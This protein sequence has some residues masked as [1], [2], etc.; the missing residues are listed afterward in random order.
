[1][2]TLISFSRT[3]L[4]VKW[5]APLGLT[6]T[7]L[8]LTAGNTFAQSNANGDAATETAAPSIAIKH[9]AS[10]SYLMPGE[11]A[12][13]TVVVT[14]T[15]NVTLDNVK[16]TNPNVADCAHQ[17]GEMTP[18]QVVAYSCE[19]AEIY[20]TTTS[21]VTV[22]GSATNLP[23]VVASAEAQIDV[24]NAVFSIMQ[25]PVQGQARRGD[26]IIMTYNY[27]NSGAGAAIGVQLVEFVPDGTNFVPEA[28][29]GWTCENGSIEAGTM[30][31]Y[32]IER[33]EAGE[34]ASGQ[35]PFVVVKLAD[36]ADR[37]ETT[38]AGSGS[39]VG[40]QTQNISLFLP[41]IN[42]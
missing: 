40:N 24:V 9:S 37:E 15:G 8:L 11:T 30:C 3:Y 28:S 1:M 29:A 42:S 33:I 23:L 26:N 27:T 31:Y 35:F 25:E 36:A 10:D 20:E 12:S 6:L 21:K 39:V 34:S 5:V 22:I 32:S 16:V 14:N 13:F 17:I 7:C 38:V 41:I 4:P 19:L 18:G 2:K